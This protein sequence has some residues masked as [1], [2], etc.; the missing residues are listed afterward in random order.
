MANLTKLILEPFEIVAEESSKGSGK[1]DAVVYQG[2]HGYCLNRHCI[3]KARAEAIVEE[4][5]TNPVAFLETHILG[6]TDKFREYSPAWRVAGRSRH[7]AEQTSKLLAR[8]LYSL[9]PD[10]RELMSF[11]FEPK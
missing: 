2:D 10:V 6:G 3:G 7:S 9:K 11:A 8:Y 1:Y 4:C 5:H